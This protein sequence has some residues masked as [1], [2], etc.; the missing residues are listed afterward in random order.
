MAF[1]MRLDDVGYKGTVDYRETE[2]GH[3]WRWWTKWLRERDLPFFYQRLAPPLSGEV[4]ASPLPETFRYRSIFPSFGVWGYDVTVTRD[5]SEFLDLTDVREAG[6][7]VQ[8]SGR[9]E[10]TTAP[11]YRANEAYQVSVDEGAPVE[12]VADPDGRLTIDVDLG[13]SHTSDQFTE[14]ADVA[15]KLGGYFTVRKVSISGAGIAVT[16]PVLASSASGAAST[17][18]SGGAR[19]VPAIGGSAG[20]G[21][22]HVTSTGAE[23]S[24]TAGATPVADTSPLTEPVRRVSVPL[25]ALMLALVSG[26]SGFWWRRRQTAQQAHS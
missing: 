9:A 5:V 21:S 12:V 23:R 26:G 11:R 8:G 15:E 24:S 3:A 22:L 13:P 4:A 20:A 6:F 19:V 16:S 14:Q 7:T 2:G 18:S 1:R 25:T 10:V 17:T